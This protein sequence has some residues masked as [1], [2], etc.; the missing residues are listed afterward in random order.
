MNN[1][2]VQMEYEKAIDYIFGMIQ[3]GDLTV[4]SKLPTERA[5]AQ[6]LN[7]GRN[8]TREALS[9]LH[10]M[11]MVKSVQGSGNYICADANKTIFQILTV[12]LALGSITKKDVCEFRRAMEKTV[13]ML[14]LEKGISEDADKKMKSLLDNMKK[15]QL[16]SG[17][18]SECG[19]ESDLQESYE[20]PAV[21]SDKEFHAL[22][23]TATHNEL[24]STIMGAVMTVYHEWIELVLKKADPETKNNLVSYHEDIYNGIKDKN[25]SLVNE[26]IDKH[27]NLI[28]ELLIV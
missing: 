4:G 9:I 12:M 17:S 21:R 16:A 2:G 22:L 14:L 19:I 7:I 27:Y 15:D 18:S 23:V 10:G 20:N 6:E 26:A 3:N 1:T 25:E 8:S 24:L 5:I 13:C 11:G 28:E